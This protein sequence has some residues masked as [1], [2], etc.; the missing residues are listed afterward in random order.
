MSN[1]FNNFE[2][3]NKYIIN[4]LQITQKYTSSL[5]KDI[6]G[7]SIIIVCVLPDKK[8]DVALDDI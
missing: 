1:E 7:S 8:Y 5:S 2:R 4:Y 3:Q 6:Q